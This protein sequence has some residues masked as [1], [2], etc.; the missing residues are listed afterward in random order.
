MLL[1]N[2]GETHSTETIR[3]YHDEYDNV[4]G[5]M[6]DGHGMCNNDRRGTGHCDHAVH[7]FSSR[8]VSC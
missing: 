2:W 1:A 4:E 6:C 3:D 8:K 7:T 5:S